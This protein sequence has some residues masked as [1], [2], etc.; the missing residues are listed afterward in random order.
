MM[1]LRN[2][3]KDCKEGDFSRNSI[4]DGIAAPGHATA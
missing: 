2:E 4:S 3:Y 1:K